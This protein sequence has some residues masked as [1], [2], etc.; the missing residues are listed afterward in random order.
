MES[1]VMLLH[2]LYDNIGAIQIAHD[3]MEYELT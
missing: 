3:D 1:Y 2:L